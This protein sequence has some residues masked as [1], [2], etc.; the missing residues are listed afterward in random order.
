MGRKGQELRDK[1]GLCKLENVKE[2]NSPKEMYSNLD[3]T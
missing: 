1:G 2:W 3:F